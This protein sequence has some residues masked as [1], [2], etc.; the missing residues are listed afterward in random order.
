MIAV[1]LLLLLLRRCLCVVLFLRP[2]NCPDTI[3]NSPRPQIFGVVICSAKKRTD[4]CLHRSAHPLASVPITGAQGMS[5][6]A[7]LSQAL[8][9]CFI[10]DLNIIA[11]FVL[12]EL[13]EL[14]DC[15]VRR[16]IGVLVV[17]SA[18]KSPLQPLPDACP[19]G[20]QPRV[21]FYRINDLNI[22]SLDSRERW[23]AV[24]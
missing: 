9:G 21:I 19:L 23:E 7:L 11:S 5:E 2:W 13:I 24:L 1:V 20:R 6:F 8:A 3:V 10:S 4:G 12:V 18:A 22:P 15:T 17:C 16:G 14:P